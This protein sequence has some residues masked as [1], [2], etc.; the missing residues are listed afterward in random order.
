M[1]FILFCTLALPTAAFAQNPTSTQKFRPIDPTLNVPIP[2][3]SFTPADQLT[4]ESVDGS[5][6]FSIPYIGEYI[7]GVV[8]YAMS[9]IVLIALLMILL[10]GVRWILARGDASAIKEA[11]HMITGAIGGVC[12][13]LG[14]YGILSVINPDLTVFKSVNVTAVQGENYELYDDSVPEELGP[15]FEASMAQDLSGATPPGPVDAAAYAQKPFYPADKCGDSATMVAIMD[16][17]LLKPIC[18]GPCHCAPW[19]TRVLVQSGCTID[20]KWRTGVVKHLKSALYTKMKKAD[21]SPMWIEKKGK[22]PGIAPGD[23]VFW[24]NGHTGIYYGNGQIVDSGTSAAN[25]KHCQK[26][27]PECSNETKPWDPKVKTGGICNACSLIPKEAP[28]KGLW[29]SDGM[30]TNP[31]QPC[32]AYLDKN[33]GKDKGMK[34]YIKQYNID[35]GLLTPDGKTIKG[36]TPIKCS[37]YSSQC[38]GKRPSK[39]YDS[40][41]HFVGK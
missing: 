41:A 18:Q 3:V 27:A 9:V 40:Y 35:Q 30:L 10:A 39:D 13:A 26:V 24:G 29:T 32:R 36:K 14:A 20:P 16:K 11:K 17:F 25:W 23:I 4:A 28:Q 31:N 34:E 21:G 19:V 8:G 22:D 15:Q 2:G 5:K 33:N 37:C 38:I 7:G 6:R 12:I 1:F